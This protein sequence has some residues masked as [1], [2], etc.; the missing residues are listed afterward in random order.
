MCFL[1]ALGDSWLS[2]FLDGHLDGIQFLAI[3]NYTTVNICAYVFVW[4]LSFLLVRY[5]G[6]GFL[7]H[8]LS[9]CLTF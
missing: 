1:H 5:L 6:V 9:I 4:L 3:R 8:L 2:E 7:G